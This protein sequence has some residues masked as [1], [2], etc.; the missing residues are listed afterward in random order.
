MSILSYKLGLLTRNNKDV[1]VL[2]ENFLNNDDRWCLASACGCKLQP[3]VK[4]V[5]R[6]VERGY[7]NL[8]RWSDFKGYPY[9]ELY[10]RTKN[11]WDLIAEQGDVELML[12]NKLKSD[13]YKKW[14][15]LKHTGKNTDELTQQMVNIFRIPKAEYE[16]AIKLD[17][18][19]YCCRGY[20]DEIFSS[21]QSYLADSN[22]ADIVYQQ[23]NLEMF[24]WA[25]DN[26][27]FLNYDNY[28]SVPDTIEDVNILIKVSNCRIRF[29]RFGKNPDF[30]LKILTVV[31]QFGYDLED[32]VT[33]QKLK[34]KIHQKIE[35][36]IRELRIQK[37]DVMMKQSM[38]KMK[39]RFENGKCNNR[40]NKQCNNRCN[41]QC[42]NRRNKRCDKFPI[43][44]KRYIPLV[45]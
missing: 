24:N 16:E 5:E 4:F 33:G 3:P 17:A 36:R 38:E 43:S 29:G 6:A 27:C 9:R 39:R 26:N 45:K 18:T 1:G 19:N 25:L 44:K 34:R 28:Y 40:W 2:I 13:L 14:W 15:T 23:G 42:N 30:K 21:R 37:H 35:T 20:V 10:S 7:Y 12:Y 31:N 41:K 8:V 32:Y 11:I 22:F